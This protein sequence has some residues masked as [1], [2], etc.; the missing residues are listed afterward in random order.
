MSFL[1]TFQQEM[2]TIVIL[3]L[4]SLVTFFIFYPNVQFKTALHYVNVTI[5]AYQTCHQAADF[6]PVIK[7]T[8]IICIDT[9]YLKKNCQYKDDIGI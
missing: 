8:V 9:I 1:A 5:P 6:Y 3:K 7:S 2:H 4:C